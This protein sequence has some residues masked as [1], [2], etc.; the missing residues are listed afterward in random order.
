M[1]VM[2]DFKVEEKIQ[3]EI[4]K[5]LLLT[6]NYISEEVSIHEMEKGI[7]KRLLKLG[8]EKII[9]IDFSLPKR[10]LTTQWLL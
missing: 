10:P 9:Q 8:F 2:K 1:Q 5:L 4:E 6:D 7:L 3:A